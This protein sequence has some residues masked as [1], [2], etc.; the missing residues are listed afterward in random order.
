MS[1]MVR[2][3]KE[4]GGTCTGDRQTGG[5]TDGEIAEH[6]RASA[7]ERNVEVS[8]AGTWESNELAHGLQ[9]SDSR[10]QLSSWC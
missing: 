10:G 4:G 5:Q 3:T 9:L 2:Q 8:E 6:H 1:F 7:S